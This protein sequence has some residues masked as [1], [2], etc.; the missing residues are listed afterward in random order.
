M[1]KWHMEG[2]LRLERRGRKLQV[3]DPG[4]KTLWSRVVDDRNEHPVFLARVMR[5]FRP[6]TNGQM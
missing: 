3:L 4:Q 2:I 5:V 1:K 6:R